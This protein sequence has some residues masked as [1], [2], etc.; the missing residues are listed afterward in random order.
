METYNLNQNSG[1]GEHVTET[2]VFSDHPL[3]TFH[4]LLYDSLMPWL[5]ENDEPLLYRIILPELLQQSNLFFKTLLKI[6]RRRN[7]ILSP[8]LKKEWEAYINIS[9]D[10]RAVRIY[11]SIIAMK[12]SGDKNFFYQIL[13]LQS[14]KY[15]QSLLTTLMG[16]ASETMKLFLVNQWMKTIYDLRHRTHQLF[17]AG[18]YP[19]DAII[20]FFTD[21]VLRVLESEILHLYRSWCEPA[22]LIDNLNN[23]TPDHPSLAQNH[24]AAHTMERWFKTIY[25]P[26]FIDRKQPVAETIL[27]L[28]REEEE[29]N[30][31]AFL[32]DFAQYKNPPVKEPEKSTGEVSIPTAAATDAVIGTR[33]AR[34]L[35]GIGKTKLLQLCKNNEIPH[36]RIGK[37]IKFHRSDIL[38]FRDTGDPKPTI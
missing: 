6:Y 4:H 35:L 19:D 14:L 22:S 1:K 32:E 11:K 10:E 30:W 3:Q 21:L 2:P 29:K 34:E 25:F 7:L 18:Q 24:T 13:I 26:E 27:S 31:E 8:L 20:L 37:L 17:A 12:V 15:S 38:K 23:L 33:E 9:L 5:S 16:E 28:N 36:F